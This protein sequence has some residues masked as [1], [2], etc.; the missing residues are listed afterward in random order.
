[1]RQDL[2]TAREQSAAAVDAAE[3]CQPLRGDDPLFQRFLERLVEQR[4]RLASAGVG[5][6]RPLPPPA[7][8][9]VSEDP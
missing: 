4:D 2:T 7:A 6:E 5:S 1:M 9:P 3:K 8:Q